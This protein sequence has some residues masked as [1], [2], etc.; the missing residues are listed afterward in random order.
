MNLLEILPIL[1]WLKIV[2]ASVAY[3]AIGALWYSPVM[4]AKQWAA[5]NKFAK[6]FFKQKM[7]MPMILGGSFAMIMLAI[8]NFTMLLGP[9]PTR[10]FSTIMGILIAVGFMLPVLGINMIYTRKPIR[11]L[12]IDAGYHIIGMALAGT[13][14]GWR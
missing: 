13:I 8:V 10:P 12:A 4:F 14:L 6:D 9:A 11:L 5:D 7:N 3:F 1:P 2:L